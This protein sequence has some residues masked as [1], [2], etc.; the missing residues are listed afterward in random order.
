MRQRLVGATITVII[1]VTGVFGGAP[2]VSASASATTQGA[3]GLAAAMPA[4][5]TSCYHTSVSGVFNG[6]KGT[7]HYLICYDTVRCQWVVV[8][9]SFVPAPC[10]PGRPC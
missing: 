8:S 1:A 4:A 10:Q 9:R 5:L 6:M 3:S 2:A 7:W